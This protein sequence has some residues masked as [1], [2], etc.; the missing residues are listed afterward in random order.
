MAYIPF[1]YKEMHLIYYFGHNSSWLRVKRQVLY[2]LKIA[3][4][5]TWYSRQ[6]GRS[7]Y[8]DDLC[9]IETFR[10]AANMHGIKLSM[11]VKP[12]KSK[13]ESFE[14]YSFYNGSRKV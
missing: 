6:K 12:N 13:I 1:M 14:R 5:I 3:D 8:L 7:V 9:D 10:N 4:K 11:V 2:N